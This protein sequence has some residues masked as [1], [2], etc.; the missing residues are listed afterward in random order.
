M[1]AEKLSN[2]KLSATD[3]LNHLEE[4]QTALGCTAKTKPEFWERLLYGKFFDQQ[5]LLYGKLFDQHGVWIRCWCRDFEGSPPFKTQY[6]LGVY[7]VSKSNG[8][9]DRRTVS[10]QRIQKLYLLLMLL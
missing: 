6:D 5:V 3:M 8:P 7:I 9:T 2:L 1:E 10:S 4:E